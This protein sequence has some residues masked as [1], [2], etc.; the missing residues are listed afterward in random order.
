MK[1]LQLKKEVVARLNDKQMEGVKG[2]LD[3]VLPPATMGI[4]QSCPCLPISEN[5]KSICEL[6]CPDPQES[7]FVTLCNC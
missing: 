7:L 4:K 3:T 1:K 5:D 6:N 2:G